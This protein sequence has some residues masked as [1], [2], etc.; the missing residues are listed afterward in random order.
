MGSRPPRPQSWSC[1]STST[2]DLQ[3]PLAPFAQVRCTGTVVFLLIHPPAREDAPGHARSRGETYMR[4]SSLASCMRRMRFLAAIT[5]GVLQGPLPPKRRLPTRPSLGLLCLAYD[6]GSAR[7]IQIWHGPGHVPRG[8]GERWMCP[9]QRLVDRRCKA[10]GC[11]RPWDRLADGRLLCRCNVTL[12]LLTL[13]AHP[14]DSS[15]VC[16]KSNVQ[17]VL[18][19]TLTVSGG[20]QFYCLIAHT[21][22][23]QGKPQRRPQPCQKT[24][25][26]RI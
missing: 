9:C 11:P 18:V 7:Q 1:H 6:S 14:C 10:R 17:M 5:A 23:V 25:P 16:G 13:S 19:P 15:H 3:P 26:F 21:Y 8:S 22:G 24:Q 2:V 20:N 12:I 4:P